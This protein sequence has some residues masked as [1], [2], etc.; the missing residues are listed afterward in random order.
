MRWAGFGFMALAVVIV[1]LLAIYVSTV[2]FR[3]TQETGPA[4][5]EPG[6]AANAA[7]EWQNWLPPDEKSGLDDPWQGMSRAEIEMALVGQDY[8]YSARSGDTVEGL[9][10]KY[11]GDERLKEAILEANPHLREDEKVAT[12]DVIVIPLRERR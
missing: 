5:G 4:D 9:A 3:G 1:L 8:S 6:S 7:E 11:L 2:D 12:G 10:R